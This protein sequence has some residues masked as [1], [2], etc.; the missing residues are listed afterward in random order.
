MR[1]LL[2][3]WVARYSG[4][5]NFLIDSVAKKE[6]IL[7]IM[8]P[9]PEPSHPAASSSSSRVPPL[10][11]IAGAASHHTNGAADDSAAGQ[12]PR[13]GSQTHRF[14]LGNPLTHSTA[15]IIGL[16][17]VGLG[18]RCA[19]ERKE[20]HKQQ[21]EAWRRNKENQ[22]IAD[23]V[24]NGGLTPKK[25]LTSKEKFLKIRQEEQ[26]RQERRM[27]AEMELA[28]KSREYSAK[29]DAEIAASKEAD[30]AYYKQFVALVKEERD[31]PQR[32][33]GR[34]G[35]SSPRRP[36]PPSDGNSGRRGSR[37]DKALLLAQIAEHEEEYRQRAKAA[38]DPL[39]KALDEAKGAREALI[40]EKKALTASVTKKIKKCKHL[41]HQMDASRV[42]DL[43]ALAKMQRSAT[44]E[45]LTTVQERLLEAHLKE[46]EAIREKRTPR[47]RPEALQREEAE[48]QRLHAEERKRLKEQ[49]EALIAEQLAQ[50]RDSAKD[51]RRVKSEL[52]GAREEDRRESFVRKQQLH[53]ETVRARSPRRGSN[54]VS[55]NSAAPQHARAA[56]ADGGAIGSED[57]N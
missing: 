55:P 48:R 8:P 50:K 9:H 27:E 41:I 15:T 53:E 2:L 20:M 19:A 54:T 31:S 46:A 14:G 6:D 56:G 13:S 17:T 52:N 29:R 34:G 30:A 36:E 4:S 47:Q 10:P 49:H 26:E 21:Y 12:S 38:H 22:E 39:R 45:K 32:S 44:V 24:A 43:K 51:V 16:G 40:S 11:G 42:E 35:S 7:S 37:S 23:R 1:F 25:P 5:I 57:G 3:S 28:R 18:E 33:A